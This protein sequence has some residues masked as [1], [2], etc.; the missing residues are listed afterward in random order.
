MRSRGQHGDGDSKDA[1]VVAARQLFAE[2]GFERTTMRAVAARAKVDPALIY[3]YFDGKEGLLAAV[4]VPPAAAAALLAGFTGDPER[5]GEELVRRAL[6]VWT[7]PGLGEQAAAMLRIAMSQ[8][9]AAERFRE[10]HRAFVLRV[11]G[12]AVANDRRELRAALIGSSL[13]GLMLNRYVLKSP[14]LAAATE[15]ELIAS[16]GP[17][18]QHYLTGPIAEPCLHDKGPAASSAE[19]S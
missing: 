1:L 19:T 6:Q 8:E 17:V 2:V 15:A 16:V 9:H 3:H 7:E 14:D 13:I 5:A 11:V 10:A 18:I 12:D 4:L